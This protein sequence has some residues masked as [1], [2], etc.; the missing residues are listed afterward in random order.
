MLLMDVFFPVVHCL[1]AWLLLGS[2]FPRR[3]DPLAGGAVGE[4]STLKTARVAAALGCCHALA[5]PARFAGARRSCPSFSVSRA[6]ASR[7]VPLF[8]GGTPGGAAFGPL[9]K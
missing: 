6:R 7:R 5:P 2:F 8:A 1:F 9:K 4:A 3:R